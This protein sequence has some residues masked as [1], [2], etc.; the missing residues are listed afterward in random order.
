MTVE[1]MFSLVLGLI[2]FAPRA[3][4]SSMLSQHSL[5]HKSN[6]AGHVIITTGLRRKHFPRPGIVLRWNLNL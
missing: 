6:F 4:Q 1:T 5:A 3:D 2:S